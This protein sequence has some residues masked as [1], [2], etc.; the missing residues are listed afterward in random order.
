MRQQRQK[1]EYKPKQAEYQR[2]FR[3]NP[4]GKMKRAQQKSRERSTPEYRKRHAE[5]MRLRRF[6]ILRSRLFS[7]LHSFMKEHDPHV[8]HDA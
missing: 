3:S 8:E 4:V 5:Y 1:P 2:R 7:Q 6:T